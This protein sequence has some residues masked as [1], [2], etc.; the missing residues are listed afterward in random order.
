LTFKS[1]EKQILCLLPVMIMIFPHSRWSIFQIR[2]EKYQYSL[3]AERE[4]IFLLAIKI[5]A[6]THHQ[7][8]SRI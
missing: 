3:V 2:V 6:G 4:F 7:F 5:K 1:L 8:S